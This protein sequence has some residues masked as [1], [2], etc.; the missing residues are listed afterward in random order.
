[1]KS[2]T[3]KSES[4]VVDWIGFNIQGFVDRKQVETIAKYFFQNFAFN[5]T[6]AKII[7]GK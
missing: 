7:N 3:F 5:S 1:M 4:L 6:F 2:L